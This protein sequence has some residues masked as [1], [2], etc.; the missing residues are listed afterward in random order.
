MRYHEL[1]TE[2]GNP[3]K[4][5]QAHLLDAI[6]HADSYQ[7]GWTLADFKLRYEG[8][9]TADELQRFDDTAG[10]LDAHEPDDLVDFRD[11]AFHNDAQEM[12]PIVVVTAPDDGRLHTQIGDGRGRVNW[13]N[14]HGRRLH[15]W[16]LIYKRKPAPR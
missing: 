1:M 12:P 10:W 14:A 5:D 3:P 11:G 4:P 6:E 16:H 8:Y 9:M 2:A 7:E 15:V 13:A